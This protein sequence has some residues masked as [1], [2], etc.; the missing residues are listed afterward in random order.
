MQDSRDIEN[1]INKE[2]A[3]IGFPAL[4]LRNS[5]ETLGSIFS[6][7]KQRQR[8]IAYRQDLQQRIH[9]FDQEHVQLETKIT[10][11]KKQMET[12]TKELRDLQSKLTTT[13][14][15]AKTNQ[16]SATEKADELK[17]TKSALSHL[18]N[19]YEVIAMLI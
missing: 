13:E 1:Y 14:S 16:R 4:D 18:K 8:D 2:L 15:Q 3:A 9:T 12:K 11:I 10:K 5:R 6:L 19:Q 7:L 17:K